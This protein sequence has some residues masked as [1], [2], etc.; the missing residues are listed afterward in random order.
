MLTLS[1]T[2]HVL[3]LSS[4]IAVCSIGSSALAAEKISLTVPPVSDF[5]LFAVEK[6]DEKKCSQFGV[7]PY[8]ADTLKKITEP[9]WPNEIGGGHEFI[10][11]NAQHL[12]YAVTTQNDTDNVFV[13]R[14]LKAADSKAYTVLDFEKKGGGSP[15]FLTAVLIK[16]ISYSVSY[17]DSKNA[18]KD[19]QRASIFKWVKKLEKNIYK[20]ENSPDHRAAIATSL[21]MAGAAFKD[22][23]FFKKGLD[24]YVKILSKLNKRI[25]FSKKVRVNNE[26]MH[27]MLPGAIVLLQNGIDV[28]KIKYDK[29]TLHDTIEDHANKVI[30]TG[31][32]KTN[33]GTGV[34]KARSIMRAEGFGTHL[35]WIPVYLNAFP[36]TNA[37]A[38]LI[39]LDKLL[40]KT[41][42]K[43]YYGTQ[44]GIH[45]ACLFKM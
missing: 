2:G 37:A 11:K 32:K 22:E 41:D 36:D 39:A 31:S 28:F 19:E 20:K 13:S 25:A 9:H 14:L 38:S 5:N 29:G 27:H 45:S 1:K 40:R 12:A 35:A 3:I 18:L 21:I 30:E 15:S 17:L 24:K 26:V 6:I 10:H 34:D 33:T 44:L 4:L 42:Y 23:A 8:A 7:E 43:A 16:S